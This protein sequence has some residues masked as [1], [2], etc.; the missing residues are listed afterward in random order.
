MANRERGV[1]FQLL[2]SGLVLGGIYS[3]I[4]LGYSLIYKASGL[5]SFVQGDILTLGAFLGLTFYSWLGFPFA[6]SLVF[7]ISITFLLGMF[8]EWGII[9]KLVGK[10]NLAPIYVVLAT[11]AASYII[12]NSSQVVWGTSA[13][14]FP[15]LFKTA[16]VKIIAREVQME[17]IF[18]II[19]A[20]GMMGILHFFMKYT[21]LGTSMRAAAMDPLAARACGINVYL[22]TG[23]TWGLA[24]GLAALGG[25]LIGP[26]Y[27]VYSMLGATIG[28]KGFSSAV[29]GGYGNMY[30]AMVGGLLLG[31]METFVAGYI[32]SSYKDIIGFMV[33][34]IFLFLKPTGIFNE[35]AIT[36]Q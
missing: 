34:L 13:L 4:A 36:R 33:L 14:H 9:R 19:F 24:A 31:L 23:I 5:M 2:V 12:Q 22:N 17:S 21:R 20:A 11:I 1:F 16:T 28:R 29:I 26:V 18:C 30:G 27:G 10:R 7:T 32:S 35:T 6:A 3:M 25:M 15:P 8:I